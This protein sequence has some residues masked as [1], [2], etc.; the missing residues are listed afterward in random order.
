MLPPPAFLLLSRLS[1]LAAT[2]PTLS[3][4]YFFLF[5]PVSPPFPA[6]RLQLFCG[7]LPSPI[8]SSFPF[9]SSLLSSLPSPFPSPLPSGVRLRV[10]TPVT[11]PVP[12]PVP[13]RCSSTGPHPYH[14]PRSRPA[15]LRSPPSPFPF[16]LH[17]RPHDRSCPRYRLCSH[18][19]LQS[20]PR[21][22]SLL[23]FPRIRLPPGTMRLYRRRA[24]RMGLSGARKCHPLSA[25]MV[26]RAE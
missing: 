24:L 7:F 2:E 26:T 11:V 8:F 9:P 21:P 5:P 19:Q 23:P 18:L 10:L 14:R 25:E 15:L 4:L 1:G 16:P 6:R 13:I 12:V 3:F 22:R 20:R 17:P